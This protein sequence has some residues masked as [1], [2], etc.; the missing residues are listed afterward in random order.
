MRKLLILALLFTMALFVAGPASAAEEP[1]GK[2][3][4]ITV[5][6]TIQ[7][8][9]TTCAGKTCT[10][11]QEYIVAAIEDH[12]VLVTDSGAYYMLPNLK[13]SR[14]SP[15]LNKPVR[16][17]GIQVLGGNAIVVNTAEVLTHG[18]WVAFHSPEIMK[19]VDRFRQF[20]PEIFLY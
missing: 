1:G 12:F 7:G 13:S 8:L 5:E 20:Y 10:P 14:L 16:V 15:Y 18:K 6:G 11:G 3:K 9:L 17:K 4:E 19:E 2:G